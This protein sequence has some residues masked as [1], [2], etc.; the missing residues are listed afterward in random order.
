[1]VTG[2]AHKA[3]RSSGRL[4]LGVAVACGALAFGAGLGTSISVIA[5]ISAAVDPN[6]T[7]FLRKGWIA[8][9]VVGLV[10]GGVGA[11]VGWI[12]G[13]RIAQ[14]LTDLGLAVA[15]LGRGGTAVKVRF[16]GNDEISSLGRSLQ[17]LANDLAELLKDQQQGGG[18][19]ATMDPLVRQLRDKTLPQSLPAVA[20]FELDGAISA[21]S[22]GGLDYYDAVA[23]EDA[24]IVYLISGEGAGPTSVVAARMARDEVHP[25]LIQGAVPRKALAHANKVLK[26]HLPAT[27]CAKATLL[28]LSADGAK[29][30][31]AGARAPLLICQRGQV[32]ELA[33][34]GLALGLDD[35]PVFDKAL[36]PQEVA[37]SPGTRLIL[38]NEAALRVDRFLERVGQLSPRHTAMFMNMVLGGIE[39]DA[40]SEGLREDVVL[41][42]AKKAG[43]T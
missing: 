35:G 13:G 6:E 38:V 1:M 23:I 11:L 31:Q 29:L 7:E 15:K 19:L 4:G 34:E 20:G 33:A 21:G 37:T 36:R 39:Q 42:T 8:A 16:G 30:Y 32:L 10:A 43:Q 14:R 3:G 40:G 41:V 12:L 27:V 2:M 17:Y 25:A 26:Q 18:A 9:L 5:N 24:T 22:R 28:M